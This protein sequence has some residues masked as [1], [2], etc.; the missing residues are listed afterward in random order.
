[1]EYFVLQSVLLPVITLLSK[2]KITLLQTAL[3]LKIIQYQNVLYLG[4][5]PISV[6]IVITS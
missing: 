6:A 2:T 4:G 3:L 5:L 1:M